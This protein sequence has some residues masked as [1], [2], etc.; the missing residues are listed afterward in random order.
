MLHLSCFQFSLLAF[1]A[2]CQYSVMSF[3][4]SCRSTHFKLLQTGRVN[5][6]SLFHILIWQ[7]TQTT[8]GQ[9]EGLRGCSWSRVSSHRCQVAQKRIRL[10]IFVAFCCAFICHGSVVGRGHRDQMVPVELDI[11]LCKLHASNNSRYSLSQRLRRLFLSLS[12]W[13]SLCLSSQRN[14][15]I[16]CW[17][18]CQAQPQFPNATPYAQVP[19]ITTIAT[20][21]TTNTY[22]ML[23]STSKFN[24]LQIIWQKSLELQNTEYANRLCLSSSPS[25]LPSPFL[26]YLTYLY[27]IEVYVYACS[28]VCAQ[29]ICS[30]IVWHTKYAHTHKYCILVYTHTHTHTRVTVTFLSSRVCCSC[31]CSLSCLSA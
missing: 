28:Y 8:S 18:I 19:A 22:D 30:C 11:H 1:V 15:A 4:A 14:E 12:L 26:C 13:F 27:W 17:H 7:T 25:L 24:C 21:T 31:F 5:P 10:K 3:D 29:F 20:T 9:T 16:S 2:A 23:K 6:F